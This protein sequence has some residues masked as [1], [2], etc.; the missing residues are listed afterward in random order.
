MRTKQ[1]VRFDPFRAIRVSRLGRSPRRRMPMWSGFRV[2]PGLTMTPR[3]STTA[4]P[5]LAHAEYRSP[6]L[7]ER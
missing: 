1:S 2:D 5:P 7:L 4:L 6:D 3:K